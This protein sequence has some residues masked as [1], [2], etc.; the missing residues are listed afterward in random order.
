MKYSKTFSLYNFDHGFDKPTTIRLNPFE[1]KISQ[2]NIN[3]AAKLSRR[4]ITKLTWSPQGKPVVSK[5]PAKVGR[6]LKTATVRRIYSKSEDIDARN[7]PLVSDEIGDLCLLLS[8]LT[9][10][11]VFQE[12]EM[13]GLEGGHYGESVVGRNYFLT[14]GPNWPGV[15][16]LHREGMFPVL[17][18]MVNSNSTNDMIGKIC[19][20]SAALDTISTKWFKS[21]GQTYREDEQDAI[22]ETRK[23]IEAVIRDSL[24]NSS[25]ANDVLP[26]ISGI[27]APSALMKLR[28]FLISQGLLSQEPDKEER[29]RLKLLNS[30]RNRVVH[31]ADIPS[32]IHENLNRRGEIA[33]SVLAI[34]YDVCAIYI[35]KVAGI[36][37]F[38]I[39]KSQEDIVK[40]FKSGIFRGHK[41]F[42]EDYESFSARLEE[43]WL[44]RY[45]GI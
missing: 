23:K 12:S 22:R 29:D 35:S 20:A 33:A 1:I 24:K 27:F 16:S 8:F 37:D 2:T 40:F 39:N 14:A 7:N 30:I 28:S 25:I 44:N 32:E 42:D 18:A 4:A 17:W 34:T 31:S 21:E 10:R 11:R 45:S 13:S 38:Q 43:N 5:T 41:V 36:N 19:Y 6:I 9:G 3:A 26:R 15:S